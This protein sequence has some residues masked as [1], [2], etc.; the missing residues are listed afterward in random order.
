MFARFFSAPA[1]IVASFFIAMAPLS[2]AAQSN[3][4]SEPLVVEA[5]DRLEWRRDDRQYIATGNAVATQGETVLKAETITADYKENADNQNDD[6]NITR[7][8]G[9]GGAT[10]TEPGYRA[11]A[12][13][14]EYNLENNI[15]R[16]DGGDISIIADDGTIT[17]TETIIYNRTQR[18]LVAT[19]SALIDLSDGQRLEGDRIEVDLDEAERDF[20]AIRAFGNAE[21]LSPDI[22]RN[23]EARAEEI[24]YTKATGIAILTGSVEIFDGSNRMTG[25][26]AEINTISGISTMTST[27]GRVGGVFKP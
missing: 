23:R 18:M 9:R 12:E 27:G 16:L 11:V 5:D 20:T 10:L 22:N 26:K 1:A 17:A 21:V 8:I 25:D 19:G 15:A 3:A 14:I 6:I 2:V 13:N 24:T 7:I 4:S